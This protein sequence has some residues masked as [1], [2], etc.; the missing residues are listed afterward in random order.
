MQFPVQKTFS[1]GNQPP[2]FYLIAT[3]SALA[4]IVL[5]AG[6]RYSTAAN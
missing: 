3:P 1:L 4:C 6:R 5:R 2:P